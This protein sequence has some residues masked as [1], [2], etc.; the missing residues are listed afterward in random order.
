MLVLGRHRDEEVFII[1]PAGWVPPKEGAMIRISPLDIRH[2]RVRLGIDA[3][4]DLPVHR[5]EV[6]EQING[7]SS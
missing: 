6:W 4:Q 3:P 7:A 1:I 2:D 5:A